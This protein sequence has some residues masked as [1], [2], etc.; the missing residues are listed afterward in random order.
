M[1]VHFVKKR[2]TISD[3][4]REDYY[5]SSIEDYSEWKDSFINR[6]KLYG[7]N[8]E[9]KKTNPSEN[10]LDVLANDDEVP[11]ELKAKILLRYA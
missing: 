2:Y 7:L 9:F 10:I 6:A 3:E 11:K 8:I 4:W 5:I 1:K